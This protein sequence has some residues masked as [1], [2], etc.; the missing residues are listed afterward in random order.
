MTLLEVMVAMALLAVL[1]VMASK[2]LTQV[3]R[4]RDVVYDEQARWR[5]I[6]MAWARVGEDV[7]TGADGLPTDVAE[8]R[9]QGQGATV[10][11]A[12]WGAAG[13]VLPVQYSVRN[14]TLLR[15]QG[16]DLSRP[17][18]TLPGTDRAAVNAPDLETPLLDGVRAM[19]LS[20]L[21]GQ[22]TWHDR[23]PQEGVAYA[24]PHALRV[25]LALDDGRDVT[26][27]FALP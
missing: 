12:I 16:A 18:E 5:S 13:S 20:F 17:R 8:V 9:W 10:Q 15:T 2:G 7:T 11:W 22:G 3:I 1:G 27:I 6:A 21:D 14:D 4:A 26:R 23:W 19:S 25:A 24:R